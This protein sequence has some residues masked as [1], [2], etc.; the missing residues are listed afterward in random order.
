MNSITGP[1]RFT[2]QTAASG[3]TTKDSS[4]Y[5]RDVRAAPQSTW[6]RATIFVVGFVN[7]IPKALSCLVSD[8]PM[9]PEGVKTSRS[10]VAV[11]EQFVRSHLEVGITA[12]QELRDVGD[13]VR[14]LRF[15][16][17]PG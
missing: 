1:E 11:T 2:P 13:S 5:L 7:H 17:R 12:L 9:T 6:K 3:N 8:N 14:H 4:R 16:E 10:D 15:E